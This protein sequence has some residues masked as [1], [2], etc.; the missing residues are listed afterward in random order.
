MQRL[1][2]KAFNSSKKHHGSAPIRPGSDD[3]ICFVACGSDQRLPMNPAP[4]RRLH[5]L[6]H[7]PNKDGA[8]L[9]HAPQSTTADLPHDIVDRIPGHLNDR[10]TPFGELNWIFTS[11]TDTIAWNVLPL[12]LF[13]KLFRQD[14]LLASVS[15]NFLLA[16]R[17]MRSLHCTPELY[18]RFRRRRVIR[19]GSRGTLSSNVSRNFRPFSLRL[20]CSRCDLP[21]W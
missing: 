11:I 1:R 17:I 7:D 6:S 2:T 16:D 12:T 13:Q 19:C 15:R 8:T 14:L 21:L 9:V 3:I 18:P 20:R 10:K 4:R 5:G